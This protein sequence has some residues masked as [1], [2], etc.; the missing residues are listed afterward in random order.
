M[1]HFAWTRCRNRAARHW[2][3]PRS[4]GA[5]SCRQA[6]G[7]M[8]MGFPDPQPGWTRYALRIEYDGTPFIGWQRQGTD[9]SATAQG[10]AVSV[11]WVLEQAAARLARG[12]AVSSIV[13]GRTDAGV[14]AQ[15]QV[16]QI[17]LPTPFHPE[18]VREALNFHMK[19]YPVA[20]LEAAY[21]PDGWNARFSAIGRSYRYLILNR[22]A[23][24]ALM[25]GRVWHVAQPLDADAMDGAAKHLL[26]RHDFTSFRA[27]ACQA[28][29]PLR[30]LDRLDVRRDGDLITIIAEARSFLHHQVRNMVGTL[31]LVGDGRWT[32]EHVAAALAARDRAKA[33]P[34]APPDGL[35]LTGVIYEQDPFL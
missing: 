25:E 5:I 2:M 19:P 35:A 4:C 12:E 27:A 1:V 16:A 26:G 34:T 18:R 6:P 24:P 22:R 8:S 29:S 14:H 20:V 28:K 23:R 11:Q 3:P 31:K 17:D 10:R 30:T 15:A 7:W 21:A 13:A 32:A 9:D 33:G